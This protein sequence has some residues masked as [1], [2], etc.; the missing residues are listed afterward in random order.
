MDH[1]KFWVK[2]LEKTEKCHCPLDLSE[3]ILNL[4]L[5]R[6]PHGKDQEPGGRRPVAYLQ[7][8]LITSSSL[9]VFGPPKKSLAYILADL[10][11][12]V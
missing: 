12:S 10:V 1:N 11:S 4:G 9:W 8:A 7:H 2:V 5:H 6:L 3:H